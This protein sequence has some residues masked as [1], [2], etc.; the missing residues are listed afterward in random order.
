M[1]CCFL[2][3]LVSAHKKRDYTPMCEWECT[4]GVQ[5]NSCWWCL[6]LC[7]DDLSHANI[8]G[9]LTIENVLYLNRCEARLSAQQLEKKNK[10]ERA[11]R[12]QEL[13]PLWQ[14]DH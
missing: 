3:I 2:Q 14:E 13:I 11:L 10:K 5:F 12:V 1:F 6:P 8:T 9:G 7:V 4:T